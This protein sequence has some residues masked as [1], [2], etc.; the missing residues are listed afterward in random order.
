MLISIIINFYFGLV[1]DRSKQYYAKLLLLGCI[2]INLGTLG[3]FKYFGF[4][5]HN[6]NVLL[7]KQGADTRSI[8]LPIGISFYTFQALSYVIDV[9]RSKLNGSSLKAQ[10]N[11]VKL[12]LYISFF[13]QLIAGP[14]VKYHDVE[15]QINNRSVNVE[16]MAYGIKRFIYG[17]GKKVLI[18]NTMAV[19]VD[20]IF[21]IPMGQLG[22][23]V[24]WL[25]IICYTLQI[26]FDF[27]GY[28]D[29]AIG[30]GKMF[31]FTFME[32]FNYPYV[33]NSIKEFWRRWHISLSTW[34]K[35]YVYIPLGGN[36][37]SLHKTYFNLMIVFFL[38]GLWHGAS[39]NFIIWGVFHGVFLIIERIGFEKV[40]EKN[41][42]K[43]FNH[44]YML[45]IVMIG[46]VFFR[47][48]TVSQAG[49]YIKTLFSLT[50]GGIQYNIYQFVNTEIIA[51]IIIGI[52]L[53]G[54]LQSSI[55]KLKN[56]VYEY[57]KTYIIEI[58]SMT[59]IFLL[60]I[61]SMASGTYNPFIYFRF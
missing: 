47:A 50:P 16:Y 23:G 1:I 33:A 48:E 61:T 7:G 2:A 8:I 6:I 34:F 38:T 51:T 28:S 57:E 43:L 3:Y 17:I 25:G 39:W 35:E 20:D 49:Y 22:T 60:C 37:K 32:N 46:W 36:R 52:L 27:S 56:M 59:V 30:L 11:I 4:F 13:P 18:S 12:A 29:M 19:V 24:A 53:C 15:Q 9:Y 21:A 5:I 44:L 40:L 58:I 55:K 14:I 42:I 41:K 45:L 54:F 26:Y 10:N 31:G